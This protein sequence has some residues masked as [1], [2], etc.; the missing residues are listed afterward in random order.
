[1]SVKVESPVASTAFV[2]EPKLQEAPNCSGITD[3]GFWS[4]HVWQCV[5]SERVSEQGVSPGM[6]IGRYSGTCPGHGVH[7]RNKIQCRY[8][9]D[10]FLGKV[11]SRLC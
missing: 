1:M 7:V 3:G 2:S 11:L 4:R 6:G 9:R 5:S 8:R 10:M